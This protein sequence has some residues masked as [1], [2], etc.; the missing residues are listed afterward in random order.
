MAATRSGAPGSRTSATGPC[1]GAKYI[2]MARSASVPG[3][4]R[5]TTTSG[6]AS[7]AGAAG[8]RCSERR[9]EAFF[10]VAFHRVSCD[11]SRG[12]AVCPRAPPGATTTGRRASAGHRCRPAPPSRGAGAGWRRGAS[13]RR[14]RTRSRRPDDGRP[15]SLGEAREPSLDREDARRGVANRGRRR[16]DGVPTPRARTPRRAT[17]T[18]TPRRRARRQARARRWTSS[19]Q[20]EGTC[21]SSGPAAE[22]H[23]QSAM[24]CASA[25]DVFV[26]VCCSFARF[27]A[28]R[29]P[30][31]RRA[32]LTPSGGDV[33]VPHRPSR[34]GRRALASSGG[35]SMPSLDLGKI[36]F[37]PWGSPRR[38]TS[39]RTTTPTTSTATRT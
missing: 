29:T 4:R 5:D 11:T 39:P 8:A 14:G 17:T 20:R 3:A 16:R 19:R 9:C 10:A 32:G 27:R 34:R 38:C 7:P 36:S 13:R 24:V 18:T 23:S 28:S 22:G 30:T 1:A 6:A 25:P 35:F 31:R 33:F 37:R 12:P 2:C 26:V 21:A 15:G